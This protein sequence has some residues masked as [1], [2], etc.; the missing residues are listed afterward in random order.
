MNIV[1]HPPEDSKFLGKTVIYKPGFASDVSMNSAIVRIN[2]LP[3]GCSQ[4]KE[5]FITY[6]KNVTSNSR[7]THCDVQRQEAVVKFEE[8]Q[9][10]YA[11]YLS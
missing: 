3:D 5:A 6:L 4:F 9:G 1:E 7:I 10:N 11:V 2:N 8:I